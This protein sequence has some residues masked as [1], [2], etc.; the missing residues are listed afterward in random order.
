[1]AYIDSGFVHNLNLAKM[2]L[3]A[4]NIPHARATMEPLHAALDF[5]WLITATVLV[6]FGFEVHR[7]LSQLQKGTTVSKSMIVVG[8]AFILLSVF[9]IHEDLLGAPLAPAVHLVPLL[10]L[11]YAVYEYRRL[12]HEAEHAE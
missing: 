11:G 7:K 9:H 8:V 6:Y 3:Q 2:T 12:I 5:I 1:M 4:K 10:I